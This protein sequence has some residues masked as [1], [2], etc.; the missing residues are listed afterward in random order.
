VT[1][2]R[3]EVRFDRNRGEVDACVAAR[4]R[5]ANHGEVGDVA[6]DEL[7]ARSRRD[8][9]EVEQPH[10]GR[11]AAAKSVPEHGAHHASGAG[12]QQPHGAITGGE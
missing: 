2:S 7:F 3:F 4:D 6:G 9:V 8:G 11:Q 5:L 12:D 10:L 1:I